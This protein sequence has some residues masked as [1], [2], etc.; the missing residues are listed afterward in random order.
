MPPNLLKDLQ[1]ILKQKSVVIATEII[2][3]IALR[4]KTYEKGQN[5]VQKGHKK[6]QKRSKKVQ[7]SL[8][9]GLT[10]FGSR[11]FACPTRGQRTNNS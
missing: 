9:S 4:I 11:S 7:K 3:V 2:P 5:K 8:Q 10:V 6:V 1:S